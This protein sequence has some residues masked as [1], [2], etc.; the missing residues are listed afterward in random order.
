MKFTRTSQQQDM[1]TALRDLLGSVD[2]PA[3]A[4]SWA[5]GETGDWWKVWHDLVDMG[6]TGVA[7]PEQ[8]GGLGLGPV[9]L[10]ICLEQLGYSGLP[11]PIVESLAVLPH[12]LPDTSESEGRPWLEQVAAGQSLAT[13]AIA[14]HVPYALD[15]DQADVVLLCESDRVTAVEDPRLLRQESFDPA[16]R[17]FTVE[18]TG[19]TVRFQNDAASVREAFDR[20]ALGCAAQLLGIGRRLLDLA[21]RHVSERH[22]FGRPIGEFQAV[23]HHL[24]NALLELEFARPLVHGACLSATSGASCSGRDASAA[25]IVAGDAAYAAARTALQ[26]HGAIGYTTEHDLH[27]WL[28]KATALRSAWGTPTWHRRRVADALALDP[29]VPVGGPETM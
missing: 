18:T 12:L 23:K 1:A 19:A 21:T 14:E 17:L 6:L 8:A 4:R 26:V 27:L 9:E 24:A 13:V 16:R 29:S 20:G 3:I 22:Q 15:A 5:A 2:V 10:A 25:K 7:V 28:T 11:G